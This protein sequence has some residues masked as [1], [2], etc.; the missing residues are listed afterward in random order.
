MVCSVDDPDVLH[1]FVATAGGVVQYAYVAHEL[2][3]LGLA[4]ACLAGGAPVGC[5]PDGRL[6]CALPPPRRDRGDLRT[7]ERFEAVR[8]GGER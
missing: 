3:G 4:R 5:G 1:A 2:R 7:S 8:P 6:A